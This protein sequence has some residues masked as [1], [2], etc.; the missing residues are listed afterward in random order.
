MSPTYFPTEHDFDWTVPPGTLL[1]RELVARDISQAQLAA[2]TGLSAKHINLVINAHA[3]ISAEVAITLEQ[4]LEIP[5]ETWLRMEADTQARRARA[6]RNLALHEY[7][8]WAKEF[9][10]PELE[11]RRI[12]DHTDDS[13]TVVRKLLRLFGVTS[14]TA[15]S[16]TWLE[17]QASYKRSQKH[18]INRY[19]TA[20]WLRLAELEALKILAAA[21]SYNAVALEALTRSVAHLTTADLTSGFREA[22]RLLLSAGVALVFVPEIPATRING[23]SRWIAGHPTIALTS[24]YKFLDVFWF[25]LLHEMGHVLLHPKRATYVDY[26]NQKAND[27]DDSQEAAANAFAEEALLPRAY[28]A[29]VR[30][31]TS[32]D[33]IVAIARVIGVA[34]GSL[35]GQYGHL[36]NKWGGPIAK[37]RQRGDLEA[38][39][40]S[41]S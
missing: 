17:P 2:R 29:Q 21:P 23:V 41:V 32:P 15:F 36:T 24:R 38:A 3:P 8:E 12:I 35:A 25:T 1:Q 7:S 26:D 22:Q 30:G 5:A 9:P 34:P 13:S 33:A 11:R 27:D 37:L 10:R 20:L 19:S 6:E 18:P 14:P 31:A 16:K 39:L 4:I 28:R 40:S